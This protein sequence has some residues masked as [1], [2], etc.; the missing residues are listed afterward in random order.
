MSENCSSKLELTND[1]RLSLL[2]LG[3]GSAFSKKY[4]Q[5]NVLV[6][7]GQDHVLIDCGTLCP[8]V[9]ETQYNVKLSQIKNLVLTH[10][11]ADHI[12]GV[13]EI[14]LVGQYV[15]HVK[16]NLV[17][18]D[19]FKEKL[20]NESLSG[21]LKVNE[22]G[23]LTIDDYFNQIKPELICSEP[24]EIYEANVGSINLKLFRTKHVTCEN[25]E[26]YQLSYGLLIDNKVLY[27]CDTQFN[28]SQLEYLCEKYPVKVI[29]H[30][31]DVAGYSEGVHSS[32]AQLKTLSA[33]I[34]KMMYLCHYNAAIDGVS[35]EADGF[36]KVARPGIW[37]RC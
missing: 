13:E 17:I 34:K 22:N 28:P 18:T 21:G 16:S 31:C 29:F 7:K 24:F 25:P 23:T 14:A 30:D 2:F 5:T 10:P 8:F 3:T 37:Y 35:P 11:H 19:T 26:L 33:E 27:P 36:K 6:V 32:Y 12:G 20:W 4:F 1:G 9:L 15:T